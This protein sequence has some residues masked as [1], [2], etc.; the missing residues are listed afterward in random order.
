MTTV[1]RINLLYYQPTVLANSSNH[2]RAGD[3][4]HRMRVSNTFTVNV[5]FCPLKANTWRLKKTNLEIEMSQ[6]N[7]LTNG[8]LQAYC[9]LRN[10]TLRNETKR[11]EMKSVLCEMKI[12]TFLKTANPLNLDPLGVSIT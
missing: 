8:K 1:I 5:I 10:S 6:N 9:T 11:N 2:S 3:T 7:T 4:L 12:C